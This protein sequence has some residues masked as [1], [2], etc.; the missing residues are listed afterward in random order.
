M[1]VETVGKLTVSD[2]RKSIIENPAVVKIGTSIQNALRKLI[3]EHHTR[4]I[5]VT[6]KDGKMIGSVRVNNMIEYLFPYETF[7]QRSSEIAI[8]SLFLKQNL[9][10]IICRDFKYV[11]DSTKVSDMIGIMLREKI[12]ELPVLDSEMRIIGEVNILEVIKAYLATG[13]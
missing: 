1:F 5:Y 10:D 6:D 8:S 12:N 7:W 13:E 11:H 2:I 4:H 9:E 3:E